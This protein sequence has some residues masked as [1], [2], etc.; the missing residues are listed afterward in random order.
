ML[1]ILQRIMVDFMRKF[2][3]GIQSF[4][5]MRS[6]NY[7]YIDKTHFVKK[8][9]DEGCF[10]FLSRPRRFGKSLFLD[11]LRQAF[12]G[13]KELFKGLFLYDNWD[14]DKQY[15]VIYISFGGGVLKNQSELIEREQEI[16]TEQLDKYE[17]AVTA[18][19]I[20]GQFRQLI[21]KLNKKSKQRVVVL[22]DEY[23]KPI[24]DNITDVTTATA[25]REELK[26]FYSVLK[27]CD[28]YLE[29]VFL[30][31]VSKFSK[32][33]IFSGL[34]NLEDLTINKK[35][36]TI[37][38]YTQDELEVAFAPELVD[39]D[40]QQ[41]KCWYNGYSWGNGSVYNPFD[42]LQ[43]LKNREYKNYWFES[44]TPSFLIY[45]S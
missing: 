3:I 20:S 37:C 2:P 4:A 24:L 16:I 21:Q 40:M 18:K 22:I 45:R 12:L 10:Y 25:M 7:I 13:N 32:V 9:H 8:L 14:W 36:S 34:N 17:I 11:T 15:Q 33:S 38:G 5:K 43:F 6:N 41:L 35:Y 1:V 44:G 27:D 19:S 39:V 26:N 23:D 30:T 29:L 42:I 28:E 31:G